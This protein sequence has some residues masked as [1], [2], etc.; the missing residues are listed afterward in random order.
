MTPTHV[1]EI[2][3]VGVD[4]STM[5]DMQ[6]LSEHY[7]PEGHPARDLRY[8]DWLY[9][10]NPFGRANA[11]LA[12]LNHEVTAMMVLVPVRF[13]CKGSLHDAHFVVNV[14][15]HPQHRNRNLFVKLIRHALASL[16]PATWLIGHPNEAARPGWLRTKMRFR[17]P[18]ALR[19]VVPSLSLPGQPRVIRDCREDNLS[20]LDFSAIDGHQRG[21][22]VPLIAVTPHYLAWRFLRHPRKRY[23]LD[24]QCDRDVVV[25]YCIQK[26]MKLG[27]SMVVDWRAT[28]GRLLRPSLFRGPTLA[29][30]PS[31]DSGAAA[32][33]AQVS[34]PLNFL[35]KR[36]QFFGTPLSAEAEDF[37]DWGAFTFAATDF[38]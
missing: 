2:V 4:H 5:E 20:S 17:Q 11:V 16:P 28:D 38:G 1:D 34:L 26:Y 24:V 9:V 7:F 19:L 3:L 13:W 21:S 29:P 30:V 37:A 27:V 15:S 8:L 14:L 32:P 6:H 12:R 18:Y 22:T 35:K 10:Q 36:Y 25:S 23:R 31:S 33:L